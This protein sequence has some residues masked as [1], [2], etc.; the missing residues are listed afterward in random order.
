MAQSHISLQ[1]PPPFDFKSPDEWSR[2]RRRFEQFRTASG[3]AD[4]APAKQV[5]T[6][7]SCLGEEA[8]SVL[9]STNATEDDRKDYDKV[10]KLFDDFFQVRRNIIFERARFNRR[11]QLPGESSEQYI[12]SLYT[13]AANCN[14]GAFEHEMIRDRLVVGIRDTAHSERLQL[15][16]ELTL[17][18]AKKAIRQREAVQ[19]QQSILAGPIAPALILS[20]RRTTAGDSTIV[21]KLSITAIELI[22]QKEQRVSRD[23]RR[24]SVYGVEKSRTRTTSAQLEMQ[25]AT[26]AREKVITRRNADRNTSTSRDSKQRSSMLRLLQ[27]KRRPGLQT[28]G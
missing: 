28:F 4:S 25:L 18:K 11:N 22:T 12:M 1:P 21:E 2:W 15:D 3:L 8:D 26:N 24:S 17:E 9:T 7:L 20:V 14:Y 5:C 6:L 10:L 27:R 16:A 23:H 13:L 19:E